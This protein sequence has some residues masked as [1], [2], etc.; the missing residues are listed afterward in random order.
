MK[1]FISYSFLA[2]SLASAAFA[3]E[4]SSPP[5]GYVTVGNSVG[6][7]VPVASDTP[8]SIPL[9]RSSEFAGTVASISG[10]TI[11]LQGT[12]ALTVNQFAAGTPY[13]VKIEGGSKSGLA[14]LITANASNTLTVQ[15]QTGDSIATGINAGDKLTVRKA[16][17]IASLFQSSVVPDNTEFFVNSGSGAGINLAPDL[18]YIYSGGQW[19]DQGSG[20]VANN[21]VLY[22]GESFVVRNN[23]AT[24]A[25]PSIVLAGEV[26]TSKSRVRVF[27]GAVGQD[28]RISYPGA[29]DETIG[30]SGLG[31]KDN[32]EFLAF[33]DAG[34]GKDVAAST[35]LIYSGGQWYDQ[36]SGE[37]VTNTFKLKAG[38]GYI[39]RS[40]P[41]GADVVTSD[42][43]DYVPSL[44][45]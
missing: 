25:I 1:S 30:S 2:A 11:T 44:G 12:P 22:T 3:V 26:S 41:G 6:A 15:L 18:L 43:P 36:G 45:L 8:I 23:S 21:V 4:A 20:E 37:A 40:A 17:T 5:V 9:E 35:L 7:S 34:T 24:A 10:N 19:Y 29:V 28:T 32:D 16:W 27:G 39:Y 42:T 14:A 13:I 33:D 31:F 38:K